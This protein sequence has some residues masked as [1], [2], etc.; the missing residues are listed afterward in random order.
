[1]SPKIKLLNII[2]L[3][4]LTTLLSSAIVLAQGVPANFKKTSAKKIQSNP[5][6]W[7]GSMVYIKGIV[8]R[9]EKDTQANVANVFYLQ[10]LFGFI[11]KVQYHEAFPPVNESVTLWGT[12][13]GDPSGSGVFISMAGYTLGHVDPVPPV[14]P[15]PPPPTPWYKNLNIIIPIILGLFILIFIMIFFFV[16]ISKKKEVISIERESLSPEP[17]PPLVSETQK[18]DVKNG[19]TIKLP[20]IDPTI[21]ILPGH[22]V[23][24]EGINKG[25][26]IAIFYDELII[27]R[28]SSYDQPQ[29]RKIIIEDPDSTV[30]RNQAKLTYENDEF[31]LQNDA[32]PET[33]NPTEINGSRMGKGEKRKLYNNSI[34]RFGVVELK[35]IEGAVPPK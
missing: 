2:I 7:I 24:T 6:R 32:D 29:S 26:T 1:M 28:F 19:V 13:N 15:P 17:P 33:K 4:V 5:G 23:I 22:F 9:W 27:G 12:V 25:K 30:S 3:F 16:Y 34:I 8:N 35:F 14:P 31:F 21:K 20:T 11:I 18:I 10:D